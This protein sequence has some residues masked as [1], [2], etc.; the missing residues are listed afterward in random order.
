M[1]SL[2][3]KV[4]EIEEVLPHPNGD[5]LEICVLGGWKVIS[6]KGLRKKGDKVVY[7]PPDSV[8][9][10]EWVD[11]MEITKYTAPVHSSSG[12][13]YRIRAIRLRSEPSYGH[14]H[15]PDQDWALDTD[16][17]EFYGVTKWEPPLSCVDGDAASP[18]A[19]F[20]KYTNIENWNNFP[21]V[22]VDGE[23]IAIKEKLHGM[24]NRLGKIRVADENGNESWEY[25]AGSHEVRRKEIDAKGRKSE[26]WGPMTQKIKDL[27]DHLCNDSNNVII[28]GELI[29]TQDM[30]YGLRND[31]RGF[32]VFDISING[33]YIDYDELN[34]ILK[35]YN[36]YGVP[37]LY[38][39]PYSRAIIEG[40]TDGPTTCCKSEDIKEK[41]KGREGIV[42]RPVMETIHDDLPGDRRKILKSV[43]VDYHD[44]KNK[45]RTENH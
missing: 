33:K 44:R 42:F 25:M 37:H 8:L 2:I 1:S 34:T 41:F 20:H 23:E 9:S 29:G 31:E 3:V 13:S 30:R 12:V 39:G 43:S 38:R 15:T 6:Q 17:S 19:A 28:F 14:I 24:S 4:R 16:V 5:R 21:G 40:Y 35:Q 7:F 36:V 22:F 18:V 27:L 45:D 32:R 11:K 26:F 10:Q